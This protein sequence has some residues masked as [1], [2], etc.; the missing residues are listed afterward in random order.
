M[1]DPALDISVLQKERDRLEDAMALAPYST[2]GD[3]RYESLRE[4]ERWITKRIDE[5]VEEL[6]SS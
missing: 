3:K 2:A 5:L 4:K 6:L 1:T